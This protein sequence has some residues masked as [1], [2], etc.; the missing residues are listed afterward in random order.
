M[1]DVTAST[2]VARPAHRRDRSTVVLLATAAFL[3]TFGLLAMQLRDRA[4]TVTA[5]ARPVVVQRRV[6]YQ[7][8]VIERLMTSAAGSPASATSSAPTVTQSVSGSL[9]AVAAAPVPVTRTS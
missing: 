7:T 8:T 6:V 4:A 5:A 1:A 2:A 3:A 9:P